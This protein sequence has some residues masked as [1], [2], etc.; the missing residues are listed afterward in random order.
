MEQVERRNIISEIVRRQGRVTI[1]EIC[2]RFEV[3]EMTARRD[4][5]E[6]DRNGLLRRVHGGAISNFGRSFEPVYQMRASNNIESKL[7]IG[8]KAAE[9]VMDGDSIA[10]D[11]GTTTLEVARALKDHHSLTILT[12]SLPIA[13]EIISNHSIGTDVRLI[14]TGGILRSGELSMIGDFAE[15]TF[16]EIHVDK[17]FLGIGGLSIENGLTEYNLE[18]AMVKRA[19]VKSAQQIIVVADSSKLERTTFVTVCPL[20]SIDTLITDEKAPKKIIQAL[21]QRKIK[22]LIA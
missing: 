8:K 18:D 3:S 22:V 13:S 4:L 5:Q 2:Q 21:L 9:L 10:L 16:Q 17:A 12:A 1:E 7:A 15:R 20:S 14:L 11:V 19:L 6:L